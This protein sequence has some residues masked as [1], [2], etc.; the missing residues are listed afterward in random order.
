MTR[1]AAPNTTTRSWQMP[2]SLIWAAFVCHGAIAQARTVTEAELVQAFL[3]TAPV[4]DR[5]AAARARARAAGATRPY[6]PKPDLLLRQE[7]S[8]GPTE[9]ST[10]VAGLGLSLEIAGRHG[11]LKRAAS[12][13][14]QA[15]VLQRQAEVVE[16]VCGLRRIAHAAHAEQ[17]IVAL[18]SAS[19]RELERLP[20]NLKK[21][22]SAGERAQ[23][24]LDRLVFLVR[25]HGRTLSR[26]RARLQGLVAELSSLTG[27]AVS[28][29]RLGPIEPP[30]D[31]DAAGV[32]ASIRALRTRAAAETKREAEARRRWVP[33]I[34]LYGA[35][36]L[37]RAA[38]QT[39]HG[40]EL[41][42]TLSLPLTAPGRVE[43]V[44]AEAR[45][46]WL[47]ATATRQQAVRSA[48]LASLRGQSKGLRDAVK[49]DAKEPDAQAAA[50]LH[51][52]A[53]RRYL[54][55][56]APLSELLDTIRAVNEA[57]LQR[58][59]AE[60]DLRSI[61]LEA[62]C[63]SDRLPDEKTKRLTTEASQ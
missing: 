57:A 31:A 2:A 44:A 3:R 21:L 60:S 56:V 47:L 10:T 54:T 9:F 45:R 12:L 8:L 37:D 28:A 30:A 19:Q 43:R 36:R 16:T 29:V 5:T 58:A 61:A 50:K 62:A 38:G 35:Y 7:Q 6:L 34:D 24:D 53:T 48:R 13:D 41:G 51:R 33:N 55:G 14:A 15:A 27:L 1:G 22:V 20:R 26:H 18:L 17:A 23:F 40:Y 46:R 4:R 42:L 25:S 32:T 11:L 59:R 52:D 39:G 49:R 63:L